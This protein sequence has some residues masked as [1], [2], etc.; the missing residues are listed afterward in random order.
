MVTDTNMLF[1]YLLVSTILSIGQGEISFRLSEK[2]E[3]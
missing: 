2:I 3:I 1:V